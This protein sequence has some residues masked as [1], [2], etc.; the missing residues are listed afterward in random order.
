MAKPQGVIRVDAV[1]EEM[2]MHV[3]YILHK[4]CKVKKN[5]TRILYSSH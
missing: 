1:L 2:Y 3:T 5:Q 4:Y